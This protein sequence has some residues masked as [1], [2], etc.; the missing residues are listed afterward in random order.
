MNRWIEVGAGVLVRRHAEL[1]LST[2]LVVGRERA[3]VIDTG[4]D[5][6]RG[7]DLLAAVRAVTSLPLV[8][9]VTH[10][11]FDHCFGTRAF[12]PTTVWAHER[13][14]AHLERTA[15]AQ[16]IAWAEHWRTEGLTDTADALTRTAIV[17][18]DR[19]VADRAT[20]DLGGRSVGLHHPGAGHTDHDL[21]IDVPDQAVVFAGDL[22]ENG[23]PPDFED[24]VP[25]RWPSTLDALL[26]RRPARVVPGHGDP[27]DTAFVAAQRQD[28]AS[29]V[30]LCSD[31]ATGALGEADLVAR[32]PYP[33]EHTLTALRRMAQPP[34]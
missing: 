9:A 11:H 30:A 6:R 23:A 32:S 2:G 33:A 27:V 10:A 5:E 17:L 13:C 14:A 19:P 28:I 22:V 3:L 8:V 12:T 31:T 15:E 16:R 29:L 34:R 20:L 7:A 1:D 25:S 4:G 21:V 24:A 26:E 18:P